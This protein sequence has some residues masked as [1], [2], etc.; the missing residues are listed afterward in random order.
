[1]PYALIGRIVCWIAP[2]VLRR[3]LA[4]NRDKLV[5]AGA[6]VAVVGVGVAIAHVERQR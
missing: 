6:I 1:M 4:A 3:Q 5:A 2:K